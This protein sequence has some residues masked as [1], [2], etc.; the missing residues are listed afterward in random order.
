MNTEA[1]QGGGKGGLIVLVLIIAGAVFGIMQLQKKA[2]ADAAKALVD[3]KAAFEAK[4]WE[5]SYTLLERGLKL[6]PDDADAK[7]KAAEARKN[8]KD[9]VVAEADKAPDADSKLATLEKAQ[10][11]SADPAVAAKI[12][13]AQVAV[14][15]AA[16]EA[17]KYERA[18]AVLTSAS[19]HPDAKAP[20]EAAQTQLYGQA[21]DALNRNDLPKAKSLLSLLGDYK[22]SKKL[23][24]EAGARAGTPKATWTMVGKQGDYKGTKLV[25]A[26]DGCC[27]SVDGGGTLWKTTDKGEKSKVGKGG[28]W[29]ATTSVVV[30]DGVLYSVEK[31]GSVYKTDKTGKYDE[32]GKGSFGNV[33]ALVALDGSLYSLEGADLYKTEVATWKWNLVGAKGDW[34]DTRILC[35]FKGKIWSVEASSGSLYR[36]KP[37]GASEKLGKDGDWKETQWM[38]AAGDF[39]YSVEK[40]GTLYRTDATGAYKQVG[41]EGGFKD[42]VGIA[43]E[44]DA[45]WTIEADGSL[46]RTVVRAE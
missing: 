26:L 21:K 39:I 20:L 1:K 13:E 16:L 38:V 7:T 2:A 42:T 12:I 10:S 11:I 45:V 15:K 4:K 44:G 27:W 14:G 40:N 31:D 43:A 46:Y 8:H 9:A 22:D 29:Q 23:L 41:E 37:S 6:V 3:G 32:V 35:G 33:R 5:E 28:T 30:M 24:S 34:K 17:K 19:S 18:V 36:T 25:V